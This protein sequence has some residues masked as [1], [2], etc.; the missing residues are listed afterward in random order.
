MKNRQFRTLFSL[1]SLIILF[2][3]YISLCEYTTS[4]RVYRVDDIFGKVYDISDK[5]DSIDKRMDTIIYYEEATA[6]NNFSG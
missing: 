6:N 1:L 3:F 2:L 5:I 4:T